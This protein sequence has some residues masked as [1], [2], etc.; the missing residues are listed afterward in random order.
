LGIKNCQ[1]YPPKVIQYL[2]RPNFDELSDYLKSL[3]ADMVL[4]ED[5]VVKPETKDS[6]KNLGGLPRLA[7]NGVGGKSST[8]MVKLLNVD[9]TMVTYGGMSKKPITMSTSNFIFK[10]LTLKGFWMNQWYRTHSMSERLDIYQEIFE[11]VRR[12]K[13]KEPIYNSVSLSNMK[14]EEIAELFKGES[15]LGKTIFVE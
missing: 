4:S 10:N 9:S 11:L 1:Y 5:E 8:N 13:F 15:R 2:S 7:L 3:G 12:G 6:V 14:N